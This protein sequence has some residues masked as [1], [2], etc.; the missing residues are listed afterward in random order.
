M[1][2]LT[3]SEAAILG[4]LAERPLHGYELDEVIEARGV[5]AWTEIGFSSIYF[6]LGKLE[7]KGLIRQDPVP[8]SAKGR[9]PYAI[10]AAGR[11][12]LAATCLKLLAEPAGAPPPV[13]VG[14]ANWPALDPA[15]ALAALAERRQALRDRQRGLRARHDSQQPLPPFVDALFAY[16]LGQAK[17]EL[18]WLDT[19]VAKL[20]GD[21]GQAGSEKN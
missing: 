12:S 15:A 4:L 20:G 17:A 14:L 18:A 2:H 1:Q 3:P 7:K 9:K 19:I 10:T 5:R 13:L 16:G 6:L 11:E 21:D 8:A